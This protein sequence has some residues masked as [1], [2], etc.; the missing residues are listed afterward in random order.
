MHPRIHF[1]TGFGQFDRTCCTPLAKKGVKKWHQNRQKWPFLALL[2]PLFGP[3]LGRS[4]PRPLPDM[5]P[6]IGV[7]G[8]YGSKG[9]PKMDPFLSHLGRFWA[10]KYHFFDPLFEAKMGL[11]RLK[12]GSKMTPILTPFLTP[13]LAQK[14]SKRGYF[15]GLAGPGPS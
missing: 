4:W 14:W 10:Q 2:D 7:L 13:F 3:L 12:V 1:L 6:I 15:R 8:H 5:V 9:G 11:F